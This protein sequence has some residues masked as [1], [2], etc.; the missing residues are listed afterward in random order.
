MNGDLYRGMAVDFEIEDEWTEVST[1]YCSSTPL[2]GIAKRFAETSHAYQS[3]TIFKI[4]PR[5]SEVQ[6]A[7][8]VSWISPCGLF[9]Y[10][11]GN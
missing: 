8:D 7:C 11:S 6:V 10:Q 5:L 3:G 4:N 2:F 9:S 1:Y